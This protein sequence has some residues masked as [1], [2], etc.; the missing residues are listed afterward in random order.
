MR[1]VQRCIQSYCTWFLATSNRRNRTLAGGQSLTHELESKVLQIRY[2]QSCVSVSELRYMG[3]EELLVG[4]TIL[5]TYLKSTF[6]LLRFD[7]VPGP[8]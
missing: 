5:Y 1:E 2:T 4:V 8:R 3:S 7:R 6:G